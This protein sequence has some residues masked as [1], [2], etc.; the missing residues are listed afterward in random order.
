MRICIEGFIVSEIGVLGMILED[1]FPNY[2]SSESES[3]KLIAYYTRIT[4]IALGK[5]MGPLIYP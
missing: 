1:F 3:G 5:K 4:L 2:V